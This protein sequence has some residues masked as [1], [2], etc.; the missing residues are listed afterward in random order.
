[1][2]QLRES[3]TAIVFITHK[4]R[5]VRAVA[6][7][8]TVVRLGKVVGEAEPTATNAELASLMVGRPV[9]L[10]V[11]KEPAK[12]GPDALTVENLTVVDANGHTHVDGI[13][14]AIREG[15]VLAVAGVQ[16]T[17]RPS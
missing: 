2:R 5:E 17:A 15:E 11:H 9:E 7:R 6:D 4:L 8:I 1:M 3:G 13:S 14:F 10:T 12:A 16:A